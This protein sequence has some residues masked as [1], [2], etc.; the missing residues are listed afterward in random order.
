MNNGK[1]I[2]M[3]KHILSFMKNGSL[4]SFF[5]ALYSKS[6]LL[7]NLL[8]ANTFM[9]PTE[10]GRLSLFLILANVA[11]AVVSCG[12]DMWL[13]Q[14]T[15]KSNATNSESSLLSRDYLQLSL[16]IASGVTSIAVVCIFI[17]LDYSL[18][19]FTAVALGLNETGM[20]IIRS[21]N[22]V[23]KFFIVRDI[24]FPGLLTASLFIIKPLSV[25]HYFIITII[26]NTLFF[27]TMLFYLYKYKNIYLRKSNL[28]QQRNVIFY[29]G[30]LIINNFI[31]RLNGAIDTLLLGHY[32]SI[33]LVGKF[34]LGTQVANGFM[35]LQHYLCLSMPWQ[36]FNP[37][38]KKTVSLIKQNHMFLLVLTLLS[39]IVIFLLNPFL[40]LVLGTF[41]D[42]LSA[43]LFIILLVRFL[44]LLWGPQH[45]LLISNG[46]IK[47]DTLASITGLF[48]FIM[49]FLICHL[50]NISILYS[51]TAGLCLSAHVSQIVRRHI[52]RK[53]NLYG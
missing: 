12:G 13:N 2:S 1:R 28:I 17:A 20:A 43:P 50:L 39:I 3:S 25:E 31:S 18:A 42:T 8:I 30:G 37:K 15:R 14:F 27:I 47:E 44:E 11:A 7:V 29:T 34:R 24:L 40:P 46:K 22:R 41:T 6:S 38:N 21:S 23:M 33:D 48:T 16:K 4:V 10:F 49:G 35:I 53:E 19:L 5:G 36:L 32:L 51:I 52:L 26:A 45:E 9:H